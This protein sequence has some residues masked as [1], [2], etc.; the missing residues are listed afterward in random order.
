MTDRINNIPLELRQR[1]QWINWKYDVDDKGKETK[2]PL[3]PYNGEIVDATEPGNWATFDIAIQN[4][5]NG[6][7]DGIGF[8]L[9]E[10]DPY[11]VI[12]LD[13]PV[14]KVAPN[15]IERVY[16]VGSNIVTDADSYTEVS[17]SGKGLHIWLKAAV[18]PNGV[19]STA[20][21]IEL[22][23]T[24]RF[25]TVTGNVYGDLKPIN[26]RDE[27]ANVLHGA[28]SR[29]SKPLAEIVEQQCVLSVEEVIAKISSWSNA[30][31][32]HRLWNMP[33][34]E[35]DDSS[36]DQGLMN[37]FVQATRNVEVSRACFNAS[38]R[39][40]R[41][42]WATRSDYQ[43][44]TIRRAFDAL[45]KQPSL[46]LSAFIAQGR[47]QLRALNE[48]KQIAAQ[49]QGVK[50]S[51]TAETS[52]HIA[53]ADGYTHG[54]GTYSNPGGLLGDL[55]EF[56][57]RSSHI[58]VAEVALTGALGL[59]AGICGRAYNV[60][61]LGLNL[62]IILLA[63]SGAGKNAAMQA[64]KALIDLVADSM[65]PEYRKFVG[66]RPVSGA[67][68]SK[69]FGDNRVSFVSFYDEFGEKF[70]EMNQPD[71]FP[72]AA[73]LL[74]PM[75]E[76]YTASGRTGSMPEILHSDKDRSTKGTKAPAFSFVGSSVPSTFYQSMN[77]RLG[78]KGLLPRLTIIHYDEQ[79][80]VPMNYDAKNV[81]VPDWLLQKLGALCESAFRINGTYP[82]N[83]LD[84][85]VDGDAWLTWKKFNESC[86]LTRF[87]V[88]E[89]SHLAA[90]WARTAEKA[91]KLAG[92]VAIGYNPF[93]PRV[94]HAHMQWA[95]A[96]ALH[97]TENI[98]AKFENG[99]VGEQ[100]NEGERIDVIKRVIRKW[101]T[102]SDRD[103]D[104][105]RQDGQICRSLGLIPH[106][107]LVQ[108]C[109]PL[110]PFKAYKRGAGDASEGFNKA[111]QAM[112]SFGWIKVATGVLLP[113]GEPMNAK[114]YALLD[115][116]CLKIP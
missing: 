94:T 74:G 113:S 13:N 22:Y 62:Y 115:P 40:Q 23:S 33:F 65:N 15:E 81:R 67:A 79:E 42:K 44:R 111:L 51:K 104:K 84:V 105:L 85:Q 89:Q 2:R 95:I 86:R 41:E 106:S 96:F 110:G 109:L 108:R 60:N 29:A 19:R 3:S 56:F 11:V 64:P 32:F 18:P 12:D 35:Q 98:V 16:Q 46:D 102:L 53:K 87:K 7:C 30:E 73:Q 47:E 52:R 24:A 99:E 34:G 82:H 103:A 101:L 112:V 83:P 21:C 88:R 49:Q 77:P 71:R 66:G 48:A 100:D 6:L 76:L 1:A 43:D 31:T 70:Y 63:N 28:L 59:M 9:S 78:D 91:L 58:P 39:A 37:F 14:G 57:Y 27:L 54:P 80:I 107:Y 97:E 90:L 61:N 10:N 116:D 36:V 5:L 26:Q 75:M 50:P 45:E 72:A 114:A 17:P 69:M 20:D 92:L 93:L 38:P 8:A 68:L 25:M 55:M 4:A